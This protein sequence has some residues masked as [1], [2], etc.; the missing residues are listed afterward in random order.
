[1]QTNCRRTGPV[2]ASVVALSTLI[3]FQGSPLV[4][5]AD[6]ELQVTITNQVTPW[7]R[8]AA[9][10]SIKLQ[11]LSEP[12]EAIPALVLEAVSGGSVEYWAPVQLRRGVPLEV[13]SADSLSAGAPIEMRID[14]NRLLWGRTT[15]ALWPRAKLE[16]A[17]PLG[18]YRLRLT[19]DVLDPKAPAR[20]IRRS[21]RSNTVEVEIE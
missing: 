7:T 1:M 4:S 13:N 5:D 9:G 14:P 18:K 20:R 15:A 12:V 2:V 16:D 10:I 19:V 17:V 3:V 21:Y 8:Q 11:G 6:T